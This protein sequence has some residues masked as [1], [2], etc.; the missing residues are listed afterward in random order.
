MTAAIIWAAQH[1]AKIINIS[2][3]YNSDPRLLHDL[4]DVCEKN[5]AST[6]VNIELPRLDNI[7]ILII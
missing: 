7:I 3:G 4:L 6:N 5:I 2:F 1:G